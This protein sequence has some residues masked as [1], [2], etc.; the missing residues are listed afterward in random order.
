MRQRRD[1][2]VPEWHVKVRQFCERQLSIRRGALTPERLAEAIR[3]P[4]GRVSELGRQR[5]EHTRQMFL[6]KLSLPLQRMVSARARV[7]GRRETVRELDTYIGLAT[8]GSTQHARAVLE[9]FY[10]I[11]PRDPGMRRYIEESRRR[12][13][14]DGDREHRGM[15]RALLLLDEKGGSKRSTP[16]ERAEARQLYDELRQPGA[17]INAVDE[18]GHCHDLQTNSRARSKAQRG[19]SKG[20]AIEHIAAIMRTTQRTVQRWLER[21]DEAE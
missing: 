10:W 2:T 19:M 12:Y 3:R 7:K 20:Q 21:T 5:W 11:G 16:D 13:N 14:A 6:R 4:K 8:S 1:L 9:Y 15:E 17:Q 18:C